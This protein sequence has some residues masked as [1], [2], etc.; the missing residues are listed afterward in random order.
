MFA[1]TA[2]Q[3]SKSNLIESDVRAGLMFIFQDN[4]SAG[5]FRLY[6][7]PRVENKNYDSSAETVEIGLYD[8]LDTA[9]T[10]ACIGYGAYD[11]RWKPI[12]RS[13]IN[14]VSNVLK[15][16]FEIVN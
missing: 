14:T 7:V 3:Q 13:H 4:N 10:I 8:D 12:K 11:S 1:E 15:R 16:N 5:K 9:V 6:F 2:L